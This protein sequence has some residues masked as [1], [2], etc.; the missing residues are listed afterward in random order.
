MRCLGKLADAYRDLLRPRRGSAS[1]RMQSVRRTRRTSV[2]H[3]GRRRVHQLLGGFRWPLVSRNAAATQPA[4]ARVNYSKAVLAIAGG[5]ADASDGSEIQG[6]TEAKAAPVKTTSHHARCGSIRTSRSRQ[7][8]CSGRQT[9]P[10]SK[11][12]AA[13]TSSFH[14]PTCAVWLS[15]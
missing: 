8:P 13:S 11:N 15:P 10:L 7:P 2:A 12:L 4:S 3:V 5:A 1:S 6:E 9:A 14:L